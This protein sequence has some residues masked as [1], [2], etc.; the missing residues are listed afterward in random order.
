M[1]Q[2]SC[3]TP[4]RFETSRS[5]QSATAYSQRGSELGAAPELV[6]WALKRPHT[7][8]GTGHW[9]LASRTAGR[10]KARGL[11]PPEPDAADRSRPRGRHV[12]LPQ[13]LGRDAGRRRRP[14]PLRARNHVRRAS[15]LGRRGAPDGRPAGG[16]VLEQAST[17]RRARH[18]PR[19]GRR[20]TST[21]TA[22]GRGRSH[23]CGRGRASGK[24]PES[25]S[26]PGAETSSGSTHDERQHSAP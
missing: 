20:S 14:G 21:G 11:G 4:P 10:R 22:A 9:L 24:S 16:R 18:Q 19:L 8:T 25:S 5:G 26:R 12:G 3:D 15:D 1:R 13:L 2:T 7:T 6:G 23:P 17:R